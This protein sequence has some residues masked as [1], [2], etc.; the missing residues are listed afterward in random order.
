MVAGGEHSPRS[1][2][3]G[4]RSP[5]PPAAST[6][7]AQSSP[8][9]VGGAQQ[10]PPACGARQLSKLKRFLTTLIQFGSDI[11]P[12]I[13]ERVRS[14]VLALVVSTTDVSVLLVHS[15]VT[16]VTR[17]AFPANSKCTTRPYKGTIC[18]CTW[19]IRE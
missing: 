7:A 10:L 1:S 5:S 16:A 19:D 9:A 6:P 3:S 14:L 4:G 17:Y 18:S 8:G 12:Q 11:S 13:G 2:L 15:M